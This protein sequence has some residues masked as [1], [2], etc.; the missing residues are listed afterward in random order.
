MAK[1]YME[2]Q[3]EFAG[4]IPGFYS[5]NSSVRGRKLHGFIVVTSKRVYIT[6]FF[7]KLISVQKMIGM[8]TKSKSQTNSVLRFLIDETNI[9]KDGE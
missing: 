2:D 3:E 8:R 1:N 9:E 6:G 4:I 7:E 5:G